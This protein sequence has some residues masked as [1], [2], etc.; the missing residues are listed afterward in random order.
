MIYCSVNDMCHVLLLPVTHC[1]LL[2]G[3]KK[4][5]KE[6]VFKFFLNCQRNTEAA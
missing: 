1:I 5:H 6:N 3:E 4:N 2:G